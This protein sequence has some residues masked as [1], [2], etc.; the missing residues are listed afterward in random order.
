MSHVTCHMS[1][2]MCQMSR[3]MCHM[4]HVTFF[5]DR[6]VKL[7]SGGSVGWTNTSKLWVGAGAGKCCVY[8]ER[9]FSLNFRIYEKKLTRR[10]EY[11]VFKG[12]SW[13]LQWG[14]T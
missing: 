2:V 7:I 13:I 14:E 11:L 12:K 4:S 9:M 3:V 5:S 1:H 10:S 6:G 8:A